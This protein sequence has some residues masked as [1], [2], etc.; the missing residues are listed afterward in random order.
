MAVLEAFSAFNF[1]NWENMVGYCLKA[2]P[3]SQGN[4]NCNGKVGECIDELEEMIDFDAIQHALKNIGGPQP[5]SQ[6]GRVLV[7]FSVNGV[8]I[9]A[10]FW[11]LKAFLEVVCT[12]GSV[13]FVSILLVRGYGLEYRIF[14]KVISVGQTVL[15]MRIRHGQELGLQLEYK[16]IYIIII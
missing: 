14:K 3:P 4:T 15:T 1:V 16:S 7:G 2:S 8:I 5:F 10:F 9:L 13:V 12:L 11:I 6:I